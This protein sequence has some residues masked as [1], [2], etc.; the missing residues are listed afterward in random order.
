METLKGKR[1]LISG[2]SFAGLSTAYWMNK[3][4]YKVTV[5][6]IANELRMGGTP[7]DI[8]E[9]TVDI[10]KSMGIFEQI[11]ANGLAMELMEFKNS[12][13][14]TEGAISLKKEQE[15]II[16]DECEIER[17][18][19]LNILFDTVKNDV[20]FIFNN[21]ITG[22]NETKDHLQVT[23]KNGPQQTFELV[24]GCD[25]LHSAVRKIWFG[26]EAEYS[27][28]LEQYFSITIV[29]KLLIKQNTS[30]LYNEPNKAVMLNAYNNKTDIVLCFFSAK[31][32]PY[33]YRDQEQQREIILE[34]FAGQ[35]WRTPELLEEIKNTK[36]FYFDKLCQIRMP[37]WTKGR[38][39]LVGDAGYCASPA[40]GMG[41]SL[42]INGAAAL[43]DA[44]QKHHGNFELAFQDYNTNLRPFIK[45]VQESA[46]KF[47]LEMLVPRTEEAIRNRNSQTSF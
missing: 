45:E 37:S 24:F 46:V 1:V 13:D 21:S 5:V 38:V 3:L 35:G 14:I 44:M 31:E 42:A 32:I 26:H 43:A 23:F 47:G 19:L 20:E 17:D 12:D 15:E 9:N 30:Q 6:E 10:V 16:S 11:K 8:R 28:F 29:N 7:V 2:A 25:G 41:G 34:Q 22:L 18:I 4:G 36:T 39:A 40:A 27:H 33:D